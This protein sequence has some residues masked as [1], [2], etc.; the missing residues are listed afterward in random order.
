LAMLAIDYLV[1]FNKNLNMHL[2]L[3]RERIKE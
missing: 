1:L 2:L 3:E